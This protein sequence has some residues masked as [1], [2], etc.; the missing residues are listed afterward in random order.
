ALLIATPEY[1]RGV[2]GVLKN[3]MDWASRPALAPPLAGKLVAMMGASTGMGGTANAQ[4]Q[5]REAL[6]FPRARV[7]EEPKVMV[8][9][10]YEKFDGE[11]RLLDEETRAKI[12]A[13][14]DALAVAGG[15]E[16]AVAA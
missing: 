16:L 14:L 11:G 1:N 4:R 9:S 7:L 3:A 2:P 6:G 8:A 13:L 5:V 12:A 10:S 15:Y